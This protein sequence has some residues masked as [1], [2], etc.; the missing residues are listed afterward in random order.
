MLKTLFSTDYN[1]Q[2]SP[3]FKFPEKRLPISPIDVQPYPNRRIETIVDSPIRSQS[4]AQFQTLEVP[5]DLDAGSVKSHPG[6][7]IA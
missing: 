2:F 5:Q 7:T 1:E 6:W 3:V 4:H